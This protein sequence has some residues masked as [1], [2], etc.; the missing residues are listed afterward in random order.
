MDEFTLI[1]KLESLKTVKPSTDWAYST[2]SMILS[3]DFEKAPVFS[4]DM[5]FS[6]K[7]MAPVFAS[8][9]VVFAVMPFVF[10]KDALPGEALYGFKKAGETIKYAL[11]ASGEQKSV[12]Q[13][14]TRLD[15]L[16]KITGQSQ[17]QGKKLAAG[18]KETK[19]ALTRASQELAK[20]PEEQRAEL[21]A[22]IVNQIAAIEQKT[23]AA[24]MD[25]EEKE[26]QE[27]YKFFV[28]NEIKEFEKR[29]ESLSQEQKDL[30]IETK[31]LFEEG[32][33]SEA[34]EV[35]YQIQPNN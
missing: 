20:V 34:M 5:V 11:V 21:V 35:M 22:K 33:Y 6:Q 10:A 17:N 23:N 31:K 14:E 30:L 1:K 24:I 29:E 4:F 25:T 7:R 9:L 32:K 15:E 3:Q 13:L 8:F 26:Y 18:I 16:D 28:E 19:Q 27:L 12:A 2:K